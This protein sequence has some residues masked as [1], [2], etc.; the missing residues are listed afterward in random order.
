M[1]ILRL[2]GYSEHEKLAI[3]ERY[4]LPRQL[5]EAGLTPEQLQVP[6]EVVLRIVSRYTR[7]AG[8]RGLERMLGQVARKVAR[9]FATG[10]TE[11]VVV[12]VEDLHE[13]LGPE[14]VRPEQARK[15]LPTGVST[16]LAWT[17]AGGDVLYVE[18]SLL[19]GARG[20]RLTG[21]LGDVMRESARAA[22]TYV[23]A[24]AD[25]LG[26]D[27]KLLRTSGVHVHVP[28]GAVPKDGPSAGVAL[29]TALTSLYTGRPV[30]KDVAMTGEITLSGLVLPVG[31][32]KEK[33][34]AARRAGV[35]H[36]I[37]PRDNE[38]DL[39][40]VPAEVRQAMGFTLAERIEDVLA[41]ALPAVAE[42][43]QPA[44]VG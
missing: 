29:V 37:L 1:E 34:L 42:R 31:G 39:E 36:V 17:E 44:A 21:Q 24:H 40:E 33:V 4:L 12:R 3:A 8:V 11:S 27:Q 16:G 28:A 14:R 13:L 43:L 41:V 23:W 15:E 18:T 5:H 35:K 2:S 22:Q 10:H 6:R 26:V 25:Q 9:R 7:E 38:E 30:R 19:R 32:I 20:F